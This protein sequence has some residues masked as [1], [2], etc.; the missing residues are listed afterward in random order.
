MRILLATGA[1]AV[2]SLPAAAQ[3]EPSPNED[4]C[5]VIGSVAEAF[6]EARQG[7]MIMSEV[8]ASVD[9]DGENYELWIELVKEAYG[10]PQ[11]GSEEYQRRATVEFRNQ[12]EYE[13]YTR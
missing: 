4:E 11:F 13:C 9:R 1:L 2:L 12:V 6:M 8:M 7:G 10:Q 5:A 3:E